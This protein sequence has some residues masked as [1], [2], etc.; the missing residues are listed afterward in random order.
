MIRDSPSGKGVAHWALHQNYAT[1]S[2]REGGRNEAAVLHELGKA[3]KYERFDEPEA[4][5]VRPWYGLRVTSLKPVDRQLAS[6]A[7][8]CESA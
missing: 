1:A 3:P 2:Y 8:F 5:T 6:G 4:V 7:P